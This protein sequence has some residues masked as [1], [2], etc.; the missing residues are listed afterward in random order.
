VVAVAFL[1]LTALAS[2]L[3]FHFMTVERSI[4]PSDVLPQDAFHVQVI[5][6]LG[7]AHRDPMPF[8]IMM[9]SVQGF[10]EL[11]EQYDPETGDEIMAFV[12]EVASSVLRRSDIVC[13][14][15]QGVAGLIVDADRSRAAVLAERVIAAFSKATCR[16]DSGFS[17]R[18]Q[19]HLGVVSCPENGERAAGLDEQARAALDEAIGQGP[20]TYHLAPCETLE[21]EKKA[22]QESAPD[23]RALVDPLTGV[24]R[25]EK[26]PRAMQKFLA[27]LRRQGHPT[28]V[29]FID[30]DYLQKYNEHYGQEACDLL[31]QGVGH[32]LQDVVREDDLIARYSDS[33]FVILMGCPPEGGLIAAQRVAAEIKKRSFDLNGTQLKITASI[34]IAGSPVHGTSPRGLLEVS[35]TALTAAKAMG[36]GVCLVYDRAMHT[37]SGDETPA[38]DDF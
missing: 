8:C 28:S 15:E 34:G 37:K 19:V 35:H 14:Y 20:D 30:I 5:Q 11:V 23:Q 24:L 31:L 29:L 12:G 2:F 18:L 7:T 26:L 9:L 21:T 27:Q 10:A 3:R 1:V 6:R 33:E 17:G 32:L 16:C 38:A 36:R 4:I 25:G 22:K 13:R